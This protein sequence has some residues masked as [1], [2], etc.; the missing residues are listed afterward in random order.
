[1]DTDPPADPIHTS[2]DDVKNTDAGPLVGYFGASLLKV[3]LPIGEPVI[4]APD[5]DVLVVLT[6][7]VDA[8]AAASTNDATKAAATNRYTVM[9]ICCPQ[10]R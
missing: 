3:V 8:A 5:V 10:L 7:L 4:D 9:I 1:M 2:P 6:S